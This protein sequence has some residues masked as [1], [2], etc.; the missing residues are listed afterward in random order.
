MWENDHLLS[1]EVFCSRKPEQLP[2]R[3]MELDM[4]LFL[5][6]LNEKNYT[7]VIWQA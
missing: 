4:H 2:H 3:L 1:L 6:S 5:Y 7:P